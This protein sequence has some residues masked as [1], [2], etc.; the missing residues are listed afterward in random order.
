VCYDSVFC[1][2][3]ECAT[4]CGADD[5]VSKLAK[6]RVKGLVHQVE[7]GKGERGTYMWLITVFAAA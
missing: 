3:V 2:G 4:G 6:G 1:D 5:E 7:Q